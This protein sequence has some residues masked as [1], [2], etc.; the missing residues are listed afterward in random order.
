MLRRSFGWMAGAPIQ[1]ALRWSA[2]QID[3]AHRAVNWIFAAVKRHGSL[4]RAMSRAFHLYRLE[5]LAGLTRGLKKAVTSS[6]DREIKK[7]GADGRN[8]YDEWILRYDTLSDETRN[9]IRAQIQTFARTPVISVLLPT[10]N[11]RADWL[12]EAI[13]SVRKQIY[14]HWELCIADDAST[15]QGIRPLLARYAHDDARVKVVYRELNGHISAA[16]NTALQIA[17][18]DWIALLDHDDILNEHALFWVVDAINRYP[19]VRLIYSDEDKLDPSG[20]RFQP[21]FKSDW[22][23]DLLYSQ[24]MVS[25]LSVYHAGLIREIGGFREGLEG[26]QDYDLVLRSLEHLKANQIHHIPRILYHWRSHPDS[27]AQSV[28]VKPY[29]I[30]AGERAL[31]EHFYRQ[32]VSAKAEFDRIGYHVRYALPA[33]A[34][35]VSLII[36]TRNGLQLMRSCISSI[37]EK[38]TYPNFEIL[39][40]DNGSD[41]PE[42]LAYLEELPTNGRIQVVGNNRDFN[43]SALNNS[44]VKMARGEVIGLL[45]ND[46]EVISPDWLSE[47]VSHA[48]RANV[49]VVGARLWYPDDTLQ[50]GGILLG[51]RGLAHHAHYKSRRGMNGYF[52]RAGVVQ[53]LLAVTG[54]CMV[55]RKA[56]FEEVGGLN[57]IDLQVALSDVDFCLRVHEAGYRNIWTPYAELYHYESATRGYEDTPEKRARFEKE[58]QYM[59]KR[60]GTLLQEDP[61]YNPNLAVDNLDFSLAWPPRLKDNLFP[62]K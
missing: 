37:L 15:D 46:L 5:G 11:P 28:N 16:S 52:N 58:K 35:L 6:Q 54:A 62:A 49:G 22:N 50:H 42:T 2:R 57:E 31:N 12:V 1:R 8:D 43:Y 59:R 25:H 39:V 17:T 3:R 26:A 27:T 38:T 33:D 61:S 7:D 44:A 55:V 60:W 32:G 20:K 40:V 18:G 13:E 10:Y 41:D 30:R 34:P 47:M 45:N 14:P 24:N 29:S 53:N 4:K 56:I 23:L 19:E 48:L 9:I 36:L 51:G 21:Y